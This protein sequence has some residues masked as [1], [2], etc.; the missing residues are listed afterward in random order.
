M[1]STYIFQFCC[2]G[3]WLQ[4]RFSPQQIQLIHVDLVN[5]LRVT[6]CQRACVIKGLRDVFS[7]SLFRRHF[8]SEITSICWCLGKLLFKYIK[9]N[10]VLYYL[11][12]NTFYQFYLIQLKLMFCAFVKHLKT[13]L[14]VNWHLQNKVNKE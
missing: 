10:V 14:D 8:P 4:N 11:E 6:S 7:I 5:S 1:Q 2:G 3:N 13:T 9:E 12:W